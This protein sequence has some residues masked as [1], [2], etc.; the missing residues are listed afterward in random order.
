MLLAAFQVLCVTHYD[1]VC[2]PSGE[3]KIKSIIWLKVMKEWSLSIVLSPMNCANLSQ[4]PDDPQRSLID[5]LVPL[6]V[7]AMDAEQIKVVSTRNNNRRNEWKSSDL[8]KPS[9]SNTSLWTGLRSFPFVRYKVSHVVLFP[10]GIAFLPAHTGSTK[11]ESL[12]MVL[13]FTT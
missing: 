6:A 2:F 11:R 9:L 1:R 10:A 8:S 3:S 13:S 5:K 12:C 7:L 4:S